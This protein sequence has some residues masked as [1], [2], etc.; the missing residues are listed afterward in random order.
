VTK[1]FGPITTW[2]HLRVT[3]TLIIMGVYKLD[4]GVCKMDSFHVSST[5]VSNIPAEGL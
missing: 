1:I 4:M 5:T 3:W 2:R